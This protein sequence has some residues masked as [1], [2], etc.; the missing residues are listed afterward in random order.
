M[1]RTEDGLAAW[2]H[3]RVLSERSMNGEEWQGVSRRKMKKVER[4]PVGAHVPSTDP[5]MA[6]KAWRTG[7][8]KSHGPVISAASAQI[9]TTPKIGGPKTAAL[10]W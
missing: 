4:Q 6:G 7:D 5:V 8:R 1:P 2:D 9:P 3:E 10:S